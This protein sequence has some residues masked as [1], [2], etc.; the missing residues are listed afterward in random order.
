MSRIRWIRSAFWTGT[1]RP[2]AEAQWREGVDGLLPAFR[3]LPGVSDAK[4]LWPTRLED[5][6]PAIACQFVVEF[7]SR[8]DLERMLASPE[9]AAVRP[10]VKDVA[11]LFD[12]SVSHIEYEVA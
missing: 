8:A 9:R 10:L 3:A 2:G 4:A 11:A 1:P 6:P 5:S 7:A 12:G